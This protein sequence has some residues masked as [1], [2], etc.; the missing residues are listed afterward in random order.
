M[1]EANSK[2][3]KV[4]PIHLNFYKHIDQLINID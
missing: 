3:L 1:I 4:N 2:L